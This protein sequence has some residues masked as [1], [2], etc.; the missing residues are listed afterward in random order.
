MVQDW[1]DFEAREGNQDSWEITGD[2]MKF[3]L[4]Q[5]VRIKELDIQGVIKA[6]FMAR[7]GWEYEV[8]YFHEGKAELVYFFEEELELI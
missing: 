2:F 7:R 1:S 6:V 5:R 4:E 8:R 3:E